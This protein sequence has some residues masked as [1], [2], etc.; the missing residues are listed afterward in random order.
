MIEPRGK[1]PTD[2]PEPSPLTMMV[3]G[4]AAGL[5][6]AW[7]FLLWEA[8]VSW[9]IGLTLPRGAPRDSVLWL[10]LGLGGGAGLVLGALG[11]KRGAW[12]LALACLAAGFLLSGKLGLFLGDAGLPVQAGG[13]LV[14]VGAAAGLLLAR[15]PMADTHKLAA[16][17]GLFAALA[18]GL[19]INLHLL[20][21]PFA[22]VSL[23]V[24]AVVLALAAS[25]AGLT[26]L[27]QTRVSKSSGVLLPVA[28]ANVLAAAIIGL[29]PARPAPRA[30]PSDASGPPVV[31]IVVDTLRSDHLGLYGYARDVSPNLDQLARQSVVY[32]HAWTTAPWTLPAV[33][34]LMT[35]RTPSFHGAGVNNGVGNA[36]TALRAD[37]TTLAS[38]FASAGYRTVGITT[39]PWVS[40]GFGFARGFHVYDDRV[41]PFALPVAVHPLRTVGLDPLNTPAFRRA[42]AMTDA[43]LA[44]L[45]GLGDSGWFLYVHFMDVHGPHVVSDDE[46]AA[47]DLPDSLTYTDAYDASIRFADRHI[48][49]LVEQLPAD[50]IVVVTSDHGEQLTELRRP[51]EQAPTGARHGH[52][53]YNELL[54]VPLIIRI[55]GQSRRRVQRLVSTMDL[56][57]SLL[58]HL[59]IRSE[60]RVD[61][62]LLPELEPGAATD[63]DRILIAEGLRWGP[64]QKAARRG[65]YKLITRA[66]AVELYDLA[67]SPYE[68]Q[69]LGMAD[70]GSSTILR[71]LR[72]AIPPT[73]VQPTGASA[74]VGSDI[75]VLLERL[76]YTDP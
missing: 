8:L 33:G 7:T 51:P 14:V 74:E 23:A 21:S 19:P 75:R 46:S 26:L 15:S 27:W 63:R 10:Y 25:A 53:L 4:A 60:A 64:E 57:P 5:A 68:T 48:G 45:D 40:G 44:Q 20:P 62:M 30:T 12:S 52:T 24:D 73:G 72:A 31:L 37:A 34:S 29:A 1:S 22:G 11:L 16:S 47:L 13:I 70:R 2:E 38:E 50:A 58:A 3:M 42:D 28:V 55:P 61:G 18:V 54:H 32:E 39:N 43:A 17:V 71:K 59:D 56:F 36:L 76:G 65:R 41:G 9:R 35:G 66:D 6:V 69:Q 49:R 67:H